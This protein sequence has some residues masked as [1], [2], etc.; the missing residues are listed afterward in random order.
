MQY[1]PRLVHVYFL[2]T[3]P[4]FSLGYFYSTFWGPELFTECMILYHNENMCPVYTSYRG[5]QTNNKL[6]Y[7]EGNH[8][9]WVITVSET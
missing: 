6:V 2:L 9:P 1:L 4:T 7:R 3:I 8:K 5:N